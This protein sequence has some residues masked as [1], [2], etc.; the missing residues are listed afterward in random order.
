MFQHGHRCSLH[1][2]NP[3]AVAA[4]L[5]VR[6]PRY[7]HDELRLQLP[8][9]QQDKGEV[10]NEEQPVH[11][12]VGK[13][14]D[15]VVVCPL[16]LHDANSVEEPEGE[17]QHEDQEQ[18]NGAEHEDPGHG[19]LGLAKE[20]SQCTQHQD[21]Q[22]EREGDKQP[23]ALRRTSLHQ[24]RHVHRGAVR[25]LRPV[26]DVQPGQDHHGDGWEE[27]EQGEDDGHRRSQE[28]N[29]AEAD[30]RRELL[31]RGELVHVFHGEAGFAGVARDGSGVVA[32]VVILGDHLRT[33]EVISTDLCKHN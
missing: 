33:Q 21:Q 29:A 20:H 14:H 9:L 3:Y 1:G 22:L 15:A 11:Q 7:T 4:V 32:P 17:G 30:A 28:A 5:S 25:P 10:V 2:K 31:G 19:G 18:H 27:A 16:L 24:G 6:R 23:L 26:D 12:A 8:D 13:L